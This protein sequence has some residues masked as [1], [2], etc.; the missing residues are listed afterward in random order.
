MTTLAAPKAAPAW[1][2]DGEMTLVA[3]YEDR[4]MGVI[5]RQRNGQ[6]SLTY[7]P[8]WRDAPGAFPLSLSLPLIQERHA[9]PAVAAVVEAYLPDRAAVRDR[10][11]RDHGLADTDLFGLLR[12]VGEDCPG[13]IQ[14]VRPDRLL[15][16]TR[17][18]ADGIAWLTADELLMRLRA[19]EEPDA[20]FRLIGDAGYFSL[21]G[22]QPK[23]ALYHE[24]GRWGIPSGRVPT[25]HILKRPLG[26]QLRFLVAELVSMR[27][28]RAVGLDTAA[29]APLAV[30]E[31]WMLQITRY[32]RIQERGTWRRRHQ[33]DICQ[34]LGVS[35]HL[36]YE[37]AGAPG[38]VEIVEVLRTHASTAQQDVAEFLDMILFNWLV[39]G[40]DAHARNYSLLIGANST[41][42]L[43]PFYDVASVLGVA[44]AH[45]LSSAKLAMQIGGEYEVAAIGRDEWRR[46]EHD[47]KLAPDTLTRRA[48][49]MA[50]AIVSAL[51][52]LRDGLVA[53]GPAEMEHDVTTLCARIATHV[54]DCASRVR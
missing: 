51:P 38:I 6:L 54:A 44:S 10:L 8:A 45:E 12:V 1:S 13:A 40:T 41:A 36:K 18:D 33:E 50:E 19:L 39:V 25:T 46:L 2:V 7:A 43:T 30:G 37:K 48:V 42:T 11:A 4:V 26:G 35:P 21:A 24:E 27:L 29:V 49:A 20:P 14:F 15:A 5:D 17:G 32:D 22:A 16:L 28:A 3:L 52:T 31:H 53:D 34:T 23:I 47:L 9:H